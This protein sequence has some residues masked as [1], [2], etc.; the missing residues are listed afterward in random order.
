MSAQQPAAP[1]P[2]LPKRPPSEG[3]AGPGCCLTG[4]SAASPACPCLS[5]ACCAPCSCCWPCSQGQPPCPASHLVCTGEGTCPGTA[6]FLCCPFTVSPLGGPPHLGEQG[7]VGG[8]VC[9]IPRFPGS[10]GSPASS[11]SPAATVRPRAAGGEQSVECW[12]TSSDR[13]PSRV[14]LPLAWG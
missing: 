7:W 1:T 13:D 11:K 2:R 8:R 4:T 12:R 14:P 6:L 10:L 3:Q 5:P 9:P